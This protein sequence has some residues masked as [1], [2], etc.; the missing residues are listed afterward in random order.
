MLSKKRGRPATGKGLT[1]GVRLQPTLLHPLDGWIA[2]QPDPKP[3]RP[4]AIR[5]IL[6]RGLKGNSAGAD[7]EHRI[8]EVKERLAVPDVEKT[9]TPA[10]G[11]EM[12]RR[13]LAQN[14]LRTLKQ[15]RLRSKRADKK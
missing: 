9:P 7:L 13:G 8:M 10:K 14:E 5:R 6:S 15:K 1:I 2:A 11:M 12:L 4:E 3:T